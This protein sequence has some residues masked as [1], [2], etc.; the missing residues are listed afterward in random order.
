[1]KSGEGVKDN[2]ELPRY[3]VDANKKREEVR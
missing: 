3:I 1:M 2:Y